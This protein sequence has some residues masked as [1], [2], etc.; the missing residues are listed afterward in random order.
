MTRCVPL[1]KNKTVAQ[2]MLNEAVRQAELKKVFITEPFRESRKQPIADHLAAYR[3]S[4][5]TRATQAD[6][7][8]GRI[9]GVS[10]GF[11]RTRAVTR[12]VAA[13]LAAGERQ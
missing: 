8:I 10:G 2:Q 5:R 11:G 12:S 6:K 9:D 1:S 13:T 3:R 7:P 4:T